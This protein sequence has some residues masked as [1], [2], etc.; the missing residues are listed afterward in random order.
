M[1]SASS[2]QRESPSSVSFSQELVETLSENAANAVLSPGRQNT[3]DA[4]IRSRIQA[5][6]EHLRF[7][8]QVVRD[9]IHSA[10]EK[11]NLDRE[12]AVSGDPESIRTS[13]A[14]LADLDDV[15]S[16]IDRFHARRDLSE[17][18]GLKGLGETLVA[19]YRN[20]AN[21]PLDCWQQVAQFKD[22][23]SRVEKEHMQSLQ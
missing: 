19:C 15:R 1:G 21:T 2:V 17:Y 4:Q 22:S 5:E 16:K 11:E 8:E 20:N 13:A 3:L 9:E 14:L 6:L 23:V 12:R 18:P 7:Q 10:L